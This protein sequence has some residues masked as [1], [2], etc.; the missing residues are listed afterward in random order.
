MKETNKADVPTTYH[1]LQRSYV[2]AGPKEA[3]TRYGAR[4]NGAIWGNSG[5][6]TDSKVIA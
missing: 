2:G 4:Y 1:S 3:P 5:V 6:H